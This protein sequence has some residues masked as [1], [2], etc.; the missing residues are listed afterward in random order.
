MNI[1]FVGKG[2]SGK[3][4]VSSLFIS[5]LALQQHKVLAV[6]GDINQH[7][8]GALGISA[9]PPPL[10][11]F[12]TIITQ[13]VKGENA[14]I[15]DA[16][17][18]TRSTPPGPGSTLCTFASPLFENFSVQENGITLMRSGEFHEEEVGMGCYHGK[19][20][21]LEILLNHLNFSH[22]EFAVVDMTAGADMFST[23]MFLKFDVVVIVVEP[24]NKSM[25]VYQQFRDYL[26]PYHIPL[27]VVA[28]KVQDAQDVSFI[29][30]KLGFTPLVI[31][32]LAAIRAR[33]RGEHISLSHALQEGGEVFEKIYQEICAYP[34]IREHRLELLKNFHRT[35]S[36]GWYMKRFG[37]DLSSQIA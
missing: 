21:P 1:A 26:E 23:G 8:Q 17:H 9:T 34:D 12:E 27:F 6:D 15:R 13:Y 25:A 31:P 36:A 30:E 10:A 35:L 33:E 28:N 14:L 19:I 3:T 32:Q 24:T 20:I 11:D 2:G 16:S 7:L 4:T 18:I 29:T 22:D 37:Y 5:Y